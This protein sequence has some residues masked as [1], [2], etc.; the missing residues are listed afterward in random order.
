MI[1]AFF[2]AAILAVWQPSP[3][4]E[5][6]VQVADP[7]SHLYEIRI[8]VAGVRS[9]SLDLAMPAWAPGVHAIMDYAKNVQ[10]FDAASHQ[11]RPLS[12]A[13]VDKQTWR[14]SKSVN[15]DVRVSY[16]VYSGDLNDQMANVVTG[17]ALFMYVVGHQEKPVSV[18]YDAPG[19]WNVYSPLDKKGDRHVAASYEAL[20]D[21]ALFMGDSKTLEF[22]S[23]GTRYFVLFSNPRVQATGQQIIA[24]LTDIID[25]AGA[26]FGK[27]PYREYRYFIKVLPTSAA[28][29]AGLAHFNSSWIAVGEDDFVTQ[30][31]YRRF[32]DAAARN[33]V[34]AWNGKRIRPQAMAGN[35]YAREAYTKLLWF[36]DGA[37]A[38]YADLLQ[39]RAGVL[40]GVEFLN[41]ASL[42]VN[43]LQHQAGRRL[44]SAEEASWNVW[45]RSDNSVNNSISH[46]L[47]GKV[48]ALLLDL[49]IRGRTKGEKSLDDVVRHLLSNYADKNL[50]LPEDGVQRAIEAVTDSDFGPFFQSAVRSRQELEYNRH[51]SHA[52]LRIDISRQP[53]TIYFGI[54][55]ERTEANQVRIRRIVPNSPAARA[56]LDA[57]DVVL[58]MDA[59]RVTADNLTSRIHSKRIGKPVKLTIL[60][61]PRLLEIDLIPAEF[62]EERWTIVE[63][64]NASPEQVRIRDRWLQTR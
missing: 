36:I 6:T 43:T 60:R 63:A 11:G 13:K 12:W 8:D 33:L 1:G 39:L 35:D 49:E 19:G 40:T 9:D 29:G 23:A 48:V 41:K 50:G 46:V 44:M 14:I 2:L 52:G 5:Y 10:R 24:D 20:I 54:E 15:D 51:L 59:E 47:K 3:R 64:P 38:Y 57:G 56:K 53:S 17:A 30:A 42:D 28:G 16:Q 7:V 27:A 55:T 25:A 34:H 32:L 45:L 22:E 18:K 58:A 4:I 37:S 62:Q 21:A 61:G 31:G 26:A